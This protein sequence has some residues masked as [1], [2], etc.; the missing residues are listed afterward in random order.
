MS[1]PS[2][3]TD[4]P[5]TNRQAEI[6]TPPSSGR[7]ANYAVQSLDLGKVVNR[8][9]DSQLHNEAIQYSITGRDS[10]RPAA[11]CGGVHL[12]R[13]LPIRR[14]LGWREPR[15]A[16]LIESHRARGRLAAS[17]VARPARGNGRRSSKKRSRD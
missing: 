14:L 6:V 1:D 10:A 9:R 11:H 4:E 7:P 12:Y 2:R 5:P 17:S 3:L 16:I 8:K 13:V 15:M